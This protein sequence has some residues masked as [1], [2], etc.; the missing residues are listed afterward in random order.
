LPPGAAFAGVSLAFAGLYAAAGAPTPLLVLFEQEWHFPG[1][2]LT[3]AFAAYAIALLATLLVAGSLS[4]Y[5][6]RR[7]VIIVALI[8]ELGAMLILEFAPGI[9]WVIAGRVI[10]GVATGA[11]TGAFTATLVELAPE[12][13]KKLGGIVAGVA[14]AAGLGIGALLTGVAIEYTTEASMIVFTSLAVIMVIGAIT[15]ALSAETATRRAGVARSLVPRVFISPAARA[16]FAVAIPVH[17][18]AWMLAGLFMG[19]VPTIIRDLFHID[20]GLL[21]GATAFVEPAAGAL[22]GFVMGRFSPRHTTVAG[23]AAVLAGTAIIVV[24]VWLQLLPLVA[25]GGIVGGFG[26]GASFS[27]A[28]RTI[29]PLAEPNERAGLFAGV[30]VVAY[31]AFGVPAIVAGFLVSPVGLLPTIIVVAAA[32]F[33]AARAV[34][35]ES[36]V[37]RLPWAARY[38]RPRE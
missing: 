13:R 5:I 18:A 21:N 36:M 14:P 20:S 7:P 2:V 19:L 22:A 27:G 32:A 15:S 9:G 3:V 29:G 16:E 31:L 35:T 17:I 38:S 23:S 28:L 10:Q 24:G 26:F 25:T 34:P 11:A 4:D 33:R 30:Y 6:G 8:V 12:R 37:R 1:W